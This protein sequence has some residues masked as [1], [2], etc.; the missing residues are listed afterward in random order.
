MRIGYF[1]NTYP[2]ATD[3]FIQREVVGLRARGFDVRTFSVRRTGVEHDVGP[4]VIAEKKNTFFVL[5][6]NPIKLLML[7]ISALVFSAKGY[8]GAMRLALATAQPGIR[9]LLYQL[10]YFLEAVVLAEE[11]RRQKIEHLHNHLG[12]ASGTVTMLASHL[13]E[14]GYSITIHGPHIFFDPTHWALR[15]KVKHSRFIA[16][17][18][19]YCKSQM[20]LFSDQEDWHR[21]EIVHCGVDIH[22][23]GFVGRRSPARKLLYTGRLAAEKGL[24][25]LFESL[26]LLKET[27]YAFELT[28]VG[29]GP[30]RAMLEELAKKLGIMDGLIF[31]GYASQDV[32]RDTLQQSDVF[33]LPSFAEGVPVSLMEAMACGIPV[34]GTYVGGVVELIEP[35]RTGLVVPPADAVS[36]R[37]AIARYLDDPELCARVSALSREK[38][39]ADFNLDTEVDRL[40]R[41]FRRYEVIGTEGYGTAS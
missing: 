4:E 3:T 14:I 29:D 7:N 20:M 30:D 10:F 33:I 24:P 8:L 9:G 21:L 5:P 40:A 32:V 2:R 13:A 1:T 34:I 25:V 15:E 28:L 11:L 26:N 18:S 22:R 36:L 23:F 37:D 38:V 27:G 6:V 12:D 35:G 39:A 19:H 31:A 16:C 17:I 41:L